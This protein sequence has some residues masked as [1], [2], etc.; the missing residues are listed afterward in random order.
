M[1]KYTREQ[2]WKMW[3]TCLLAYL[4]A[5]AVACAMCAVVSCSPKIVHEK[6]TVTKYRD[7]II[8][9]TTLFEV[10]VE[11]EKI[12]T[13]DTVSH[14]ENTFAK[15]DAVVSA[16]FLTHSLETKPQYIRVPYEVR[17]T[18]TLRI[19]KEAEARIE[20]VKVEKPLSW[21]QKVRIWAFLPLLL[22]CCW[23]FRSQLAGII[24]LLLKFIRI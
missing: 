8:H 14:L 3:L 12:V 7:R 13:R 10:P 15:S 19:E 24:K 11:V 5:L 23:A 9:D 6:E 22:A 1:A 4:G 18:D 21:W 20:Y 17:V 2:K 16:G